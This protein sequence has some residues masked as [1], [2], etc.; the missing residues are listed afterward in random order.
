MKVVVIGATHAGVAAVKTLLKFRPDAEVTVFERNADISFIGA[1]VPLYLE[2]QIPDLNQLLNAKVSDLTALGAKM[3]MQHDV[4][5]IDFKRQEVLAQNLVDHQ[6]VTASYDKLILTTGSAVVIPAMQGIDARRVMVVKDH[7]T[8]E[9]AVKAVRTA[10]RIVIVGGGYVGAEMAEA[11]SKD[12]AVTLLQRGEQLL[13]LYYD[14][15]IAKLVHKLFDDHGVDVHLNEGVTGFDND[16]ELMVRTPKAS[17]PAD[18]ALVCT[19]FIPVTNL[20]E[21]HVDLDR[22][23]AVVTNAFGQ[24]S[25]PNIYAAGDVRSSYCNALGGPSYLPLASNAVR[26]GELVG[27]NVAGRHFR[28]RGSQGSTALNLYGQAFTSTGLT[29]NRAEF[30]GLNPQSYTYVD[31]QRP[32]FMQTN[33]RVSVHLVFDKVTHRLLGGQLQSKEADVAQA[34]DA[35]SV[36]IQN[37]NTLEDLAF[38]DMLFHPQYNQPLNYLNAAAQQA[39]GKHPTIDRVDK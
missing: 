30:F 39:I 38:V 27:L 11:L 36:A 7:P 3:L 15:P 13:D 17:Y 21:G 29:Q 37:R 9:H 22:R 4:I 12:H 35:L 6:Q 34:T 28:D 16:K 18:L 5:R 20:V 26:Q 2:N 10:K 33:S 24:S 32:T 31:W 25:D 8:T 1:G 14:T 23:G 19:G